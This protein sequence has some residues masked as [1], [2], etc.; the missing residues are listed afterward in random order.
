LS[1][2]EKQYRQVSLNFIMNK[3]FLWLFM[4]ITQVALAQEPL[5]IDLQKGSR[6]IEIINLKEKGTFFITGKDADPV[7]SKKTLYL[8]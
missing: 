7:K 1:I 3:F 6:L 2:K 5:E 4:V 8:S